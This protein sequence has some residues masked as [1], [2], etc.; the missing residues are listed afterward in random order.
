MLDVQ[1]FSDVLLYKKQRSFSYIVFLAL[2][3][4]LYCLFFSSQPSCSCRDNNPFFASNNFQNF[5]KFT[6]GIQKRTSYSCLQL[7]LPPPSSDTET[8]K[9]ALSSH[10]FRLKKEGAEKKWAE[11][12]TGALGGA[13]HMHTHTLRPLL[14]APEEPNTITTITIIECVYSYW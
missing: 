8:H 6:R 5:E 11:L 1:K 3:F 13:E 2:T 14:L 4:H 12:R 7:L 9:T 10:V